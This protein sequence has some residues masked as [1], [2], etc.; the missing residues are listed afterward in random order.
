MRIKDK[1]IFSYGKKEFVNEEN[2]INI[3]EKCRE[4][5]RNRNNVQEK[6]IEFLK[7]NLSKEDFDTVFDYIDELEEKTSRIIH[8]LKNY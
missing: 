7:N 5:Q 1:E 3:E 8:I 2:L 4:A 6:L